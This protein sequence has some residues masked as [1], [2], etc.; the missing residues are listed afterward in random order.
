MLLAPSPTNTTCSSSIAFKAASSNNTAIRGYGY[1][2]YKKNASTA[3]TSFQA[4]TNIA[5]A[6]NNTT[7]FMITR[8]AF[9]DNLLGYSPMAPQRTPVRPPKKATDDKPKGP[10]IGVDSNTAGGG[11]WAQTSAKRDKLGELKMEIKADLNQY[12]LDDLATEE[13][14]LDLCLLDGVNA[15]VKMVDCGGVHHDLNL[16]TGSSGS[17]EEVQNAMSD[18]VQMKQS[19]EK[20]DTSASP[21]MITKEEYQRHLY[22]MTEKVNQ[23]RISHPCAPTEDN[24]I[25][26]DT[27]LQASTYSSTS[28]L[29]PLV[30][31]R[32]FVFY[33]PP[34]PEEHP[35]PPNVRQLLH[36]P[37]SE[38]FTQCYHYFQIILLQKT[39]EYL[40]SDEV[41]N[42]LTKVS[43]S[44]QDRAATRGE[45]ISEREEGYRKRMNVHKL[46]DLINTYM[47]NSTCSDRIQGLWKVMDKDNDGMID[48]EEMDRV[49][50]MSI[51][52][53]EDSVKDF[54]MDCMDVWPMRKLGMP[55]PPPPSSSSSLLSIS[56][57]ED[58]PA[59]A[60]VGAFLEGEA[61]M[62]DIK[63]FHTNS[64]NDNSTTNERSKKLGFYKKW[65]Q[66]RKERKSK[67]LLLKLLDGTIKN[68]FDIEAEIAHRLRCIYAWAD[69]EHQDG[70]TRSVLVD[71]NSDS[72][73]SSSSSERGSFSFL[74]GRKRYVELDPKITHEEFR[75]IQKKH[76]PHADRIGEELCTSL[77]EDLWVH[78]G[79]GR[80]NQE[81]KR[82]VAG[83]LFVVTFI[84]Y[85]ITIN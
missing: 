1:S 26:D 25:T 38:S 53:M 54:M 69:K 19:E 82:E 64:D 51:R 85:F 67:R 75:V 37:L 3:S 11:V 47:M 68:H 80:Q 62:E 16:N 35:I 29:S 57:K 27:D 30:Q 72:T 59:K 17:W 22:K 79:K 43:S 73:G 42:D 65:K 40:S 45:E 49:V 14:K 46:H 4:A 63:S 33:D 18:F 44:D 83:F 10:I 77:K 23:L 50:Y 5:S 58:S 66:D 84:D 41:W 36:D 48:Q 6:T 31:I 81:L 24:I 15:I 9:S 2:N 39:L 76:F 7:I 55:P 21:I 28:S 60:A 34:N 52:P 20:K 70:K 61:K 56:D 13:E 8:R 32:D 78:Q 12:T 74:G 71:T